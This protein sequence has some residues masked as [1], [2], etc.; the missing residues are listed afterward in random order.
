MRKAS[1]LIDLARK[2]PRYLA[3]GGIPYLCHILFA[4]EQEDTITWDEIWHAKRAITAGIGGRIYLR[5]H[6]RLTGVINHL[7]DENSPEFPACAQAFWEELIK[8]LQVAG[9]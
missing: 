6:L 5:N 3:K 4:L 8:K 9:N 7:S 1:E 2:D